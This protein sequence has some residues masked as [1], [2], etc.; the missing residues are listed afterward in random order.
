MKPALDVTVTATVRADILRM[1]LRSFHKNFL[2]NF[3]ARIIINVDPVG[4]TQSH[5][6]NDMVNICRELFD[7]VVYRTPD[8][9]SF[10]AA[11]QWCWQQVETDVFFHL[12]DDWILRRPVDP[13]DMLRA[14][15]DPK[16]TGITLNKWNKKRLCRWIE[17]ELQLKPE[18]HD[19]RGT[20]YLRMPIPALNPGMLR[21]DYAHQCSRRMS[22]DKDPEGQLGEL[23][24]Q[25][26][27]P[28]EAPVFLWRFSNEVILIDIG[29][30]W[31]KARFIHK[32]WGDGMST[33]W[34]TL[35]NRTRFRAATRAIRWHASKRYWQIR[36]L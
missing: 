31:R 8:T 34:G 3:T 17:K 26:A 13:A 25:I 1:T 6:P 30:R 28:S 14:F 22:V 5:A 19:D 36:Y 2:R 32:R 33:T 16:V 9:P 23:W 20:S 24:Q 11:V 35:G 7:E 21:R 4:D 10:A 27:G 18:L 12:E 29:N 15:D